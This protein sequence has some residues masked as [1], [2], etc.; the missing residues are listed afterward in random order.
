MNLFL[1]RNSV[2]KS[3]PENYSLQ[4]KIRG[5]EDVKQKM[6]HF[7]LRRLSPGGFPRQLLASHAGERRGTENLQNQPHS[8]LAGGA[9]R[10]AYHHPKF[11]PG[12]LFHRHHDFLAGLGDYLPGAAVLWMALVAGAPRNPLEMPPQK[13]YISPA[14]NA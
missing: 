12:D 1:G 3:F 9:G 14:G 2:S 8:A 4:D 10:G 5:G 13:V 7:L 11:S 6:K